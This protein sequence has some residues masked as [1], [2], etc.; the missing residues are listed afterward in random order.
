MNRES[1]SLLLEMLIALTLLTVGLLGYLSSFASCFSLSED[2]SEYE[3]ARIA[4]ENVSETLRTSD[5]ESVYANYNWALLDVPG[6]ESGYYVGSNV[7]AFVIV[8]CYTNETFLPA[9]FGPL[10]D[11]NGTGG[12]QTVDCSTT[13]KLLPVRLFLMFTVGNT[14]RFLDWYMVLRP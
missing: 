13:Y 2:V 8:I 14:P 5:F 6:L 7:N 9:E 10:L 11:I 12:L 3:K 4:L 1:G